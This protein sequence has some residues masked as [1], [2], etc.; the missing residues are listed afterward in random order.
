MLMRP[1]KIPVQITT[2][3]LLLSMQVFSQTTAVSGNTI[4]SDIEKIVKDYPNHF[5]N[6][7]GEQLA[8]NPQSTD[9]KSGVVVNGAE[10]CVVTK[11]S[12]SKKDIYSWRGTMLTTDDF[13]IAKKKFRNL[14][15]QLNNLAVSFGN[16]QLFYFRAP[17]EVPTDAK[18]FTSAILSSDPNN[19]TV[20][21]LKVELVM[22]YVL[23]EWKIS[24]L[25]YERDRADNERGETR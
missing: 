16:S 19:E 7:I 20:K 18:K 5:Q 9:Y 25:V 17:Y 21:N 10:E 13:E 8:Q 24:I 6:I 1:V 3:C 12:S 11:Y 4:K 22:E 14:Y 23:L 2:I 15:L